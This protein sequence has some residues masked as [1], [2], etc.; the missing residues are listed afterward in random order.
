M[1]VRWSFARMLR[2]IPVL[3]FAALALPAS[4]QAAPSPTLLPAGP[5]ST[6]GNQ[7]VDQQGPERA[8][9]LCRLERGQRAYPAENTDPPDGLAR[10]QLHPVFLGKRHSAEENLKQ[11][12]FIAEGGGGCRSSPDPRQP[13][14][15]A[16]TW[17]PG[18]LGGQQRNGLWYNL[19]GASDGTDGGG[20]RGT[21]TDAKFMR[22]WEAVARHFA[23]NHTVI[24][25]DLRNEPLEWPGMS[26]WG[27]GSDRDIRSMYVRAGNAILAVD[28]DKLIIVEPPERRLPRR[29]DTR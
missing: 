29:S 13:H 27:G 2:C 6:E 8:A 16:G 14:Q 24:G 26:V 3:A 25:Y 17:R 20:N 1:K 21:T 9:R 12:D 23:G 10:L 19:G 11:I 7:I 22:D 28:A 15:R 5:F 4:V 18:Q